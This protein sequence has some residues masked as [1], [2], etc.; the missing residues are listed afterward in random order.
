MK[1]LTGLDEFGYHGDVERSL[2]YFLKIQGHRPPNA[3]VKSFAG[4]FPS[5]GTFEESGWE[6][7][8]EST[9]YGVIAQR[10]ESKGG[11]FPN[12][13]CNTG[14]ALRAFA[15]H[16]F[17]TRDRRWLAAVAPA[18]VKAC[19]WIIESRQSTMQRDAQGQKVL[20][21]GLM[22]AG[23]PYDTPIIKGNSFFFCMTDGYTYHGFERIAAAL[24]DAG[25][26]E[27][28][29]LVREAGNYR[30][31]IVEAMRRVRNNDPNMPP[32]PEELHGGEGWASFCSGALSLVDSG[33]LDP[34]DPAFVQLENYMKLHY[35]CGVLGLSGRC[36]QDD[37]QN[38]G[39]YYVTI[40]EDVYHHAWVERGEVEKAL[41]S[42]YSTLAFGVDKEA[43]GA[44][45]RFMLYDRR[46]A[47]FY[48]DSSGGMRICKMLRR[49]LLLEKESELRLLPAAPRRWLEQG[50]TIQ[51]EGHADVFWQTRSGREISGVGP[52]HHHRSKVADCATRPPEENLAARAASI[53]AANQT[54]HAQWKAVDQLRRRTRD[55]SSEPLDPAIRHRGSLLSRGE[56]HQLLSV[57]GKL[58]RELPFDQF[59]AGES[60]HVPAAEQCLQV[61]VPGG[62]DPG[63]H[64]LPGIAAAAAAQHHHRAFAVVVQFAPP[65]PVHVRGRGNAAE[66]E[67]LGRF[68]T[69]IPA[70]PAFEIARGSA[71]MFSG[72][73]EERSP[74]NVCGAPISQLAI[75]RS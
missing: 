20:E 60:S 48:M 17:Y 6:D 42:F 25:H 51:V 68:H 35:H 7:D 49:T 52:A 61:I 10:K 64:D 1:Q 63:N 36:H 50:K 27:G 72:V 31:D 12:W 73:R 34:H 40:T 74:A 21:Y 38:L 22:P 3:K 69:R 2:E 53:A 32:Y 62:R 30:Q 58:D 37:K 41:L 75:W 33:L 67:V 43:L 18:M 23:Q 45:E 65:M 24:A 11:T 57:T 4:V 46:Y 8:P 15:E 16:Y 9:I 28:P 59:A 44:I 29:R 13:V 19:D 54:G 55:S 70:A 56:F 26:A 47:P 5:S 39:S 66:L 14:S 71:L